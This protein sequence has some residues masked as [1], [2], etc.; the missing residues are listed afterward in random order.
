MAKS[1]KNTKI[2]GQQMGKAFL[3][4]LR[5]SSG[6]LWRM[7]QR[8]EYRDLIAE[9]SD[10]GPWFGKNELGRVNKVRWGAS[11]AKVCTCCRPP[12]IPHVHFWRS[13]RHSNVLSLSLRNTKANDL[14][15]INLMNVNSMQWIQVKPKGTPPQ[16]RH[17]HTLNALKNLLIVFGGVS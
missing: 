13:Y 14:W 8:L 16:P 9:R 15:K 6:L 5:I 17:G 3:R 4:P 11:T 1:S 7:L 2:Q 10:R 12:Q